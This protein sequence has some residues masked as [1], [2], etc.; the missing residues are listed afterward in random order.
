V[1]ESGLSVDAATKVVTNMGF[2]DTISIVRVIASILS[3]FGSKL[4]K[5]H[6]YQQSLLVFGAFF[7]GLILGR[8]IETFFPDRRPGLEITARQAVWAFIFIIGAVIVLI[9]LIREGTQRATVF[10]MVF[11]LS[12]VVTAYLYLDKPVRMTIEEQIYVVESREKNGNI[13]GAIEL[14]KDIKHQAPQSY[15]EVIEKRITSLEAQSLQRMSTPVT[16]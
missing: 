16:K 2:V 12:V 4:Q 14:L 6:K 8:I 9:T 5:F 15:R 7:L 11:M 3:L 1:Y 10:L 13:T